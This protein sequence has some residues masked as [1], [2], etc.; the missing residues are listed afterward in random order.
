M[1]KMDSNTKHENKIEDVNDDVDVHTEPE[2]ESGDETLPEHS[3]NECEVDS[4]NE[5]KASSGSSKKKKKD[6][7]KDK[8]KKK[9]KE[10]S[11]DK[12][13]KKKDKAK[14][15]KK[16][17]HD[18]DSD[19]DEA[20]SAVETRS[21]SSTSS[22]T[23]R[24]KKTKLKKSELLEI[25][26]AI[27]ED[28]QTPSMK[29]YCNMF[30]VVNTLEQTV[31]DAKFS[32]HLA[33]KDAIGDYRKGL[34]KKE[35]GPTQRRQTGFSQPYDV[36]NSLK[37]ILDSEAFEDYVVDAT[38]SSGYNAYDK[39]AEDPKITPSQLV[40][41]CRH[42]FI[43]QDGK[44]NK[45]LVSFEDE[46]TP[47]FAIF[48][49]YLEELEGGKLEKNYKPSQGSQEADKS[50]LSRIQMISFACAYLKWVNNL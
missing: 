38:P 30:E 16:K 47:V 27:P 49:E 50:S 37:T 10:K 2:I 21:V 14:K 31:K 22:T 12:A 40:D 39:E 46:D 7:K 35:R 4:D 45:G 41:A 32:K 28:D 42:F 9:K 33:E 15:K 8:K 19:E 34:K 1:S 44:E 3:D 20:D 13:K 36:P 17:S 11:R 25:I 26:R 43:A 6:K 23:S 18:S 5:S 48:S 29:N 24:T